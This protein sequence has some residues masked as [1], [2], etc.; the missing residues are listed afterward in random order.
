MS[1]VQLGA[2]ALA[3]SLAGCDRTSS[4]ATWL[5]FYR[6][7]D[8]SCPPAGDL[9]RLRTFAA[10]GPPTQSAGACGHRSKLVVAR[11]DDMSTPFALLAWDRALLVEAFDEDVALTFA[12]RWIEAT[13]PEPNAC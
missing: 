2:F 5:P 13:A 10:S 8:G 11:F 4:T 7:A 6:C 9:A 1:R 12:S 3:V